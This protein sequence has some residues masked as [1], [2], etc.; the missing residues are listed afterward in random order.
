MLNCSNCKNKN[1]DNCKCELDYTVRGTV[2]DHTLKVLENL[3]DNASF[4]LQIAALLHDIGKNEKTFEYVDGKC[5]FV[6]HEFLGSKM[7]KR[8]LESLKFTA[9]EINKISFLIEHHMDVHKLEEVSDKSLRKFIRNT[10]ENMED[11]FVLVDA[12]GAGT[13]FFDKNTCSIHG[14][15]KKTAIQERTRQLDEELKKASEK[16][17]R[18]FDGNELMKEFNIDKPCVKVGILMKIQ[19]DIIDEFGVT[20]KKED[21]LNLIREKYQN[22]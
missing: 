11:L 10:G 6:G 2:Y 4:E 3:P 12:D 9:N 20:L 18:Y 16:P 7:S 17:F 19:N 22:N 14:I 8:R 13:L 21:V 15:S 5:R 1:T